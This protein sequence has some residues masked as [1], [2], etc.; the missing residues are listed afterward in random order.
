VE[1]Q[2]V[3]FVMISTYV[4]LKLKNKNKLGEGWCQPN[5]G[6]QTAAILFTHVHLFRALFSQTFGIFYLKFHQGTS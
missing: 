6:P 1:P 5:W 3:R 4:E 2:Q